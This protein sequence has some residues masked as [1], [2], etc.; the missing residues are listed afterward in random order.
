MGASSSFITFVNLNAPV[1]TLSIRRIPTQIEGVKEQQTYFS[2]CQQLRQSKSHF[3][4]EAK[5]KQC[6]LNRPK[7]AA[8]MLSSSVKNKTGSE[9]LML[10]RENPKN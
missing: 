7:D 5:P 3:A 8:T 6:R 4:N 2:N 9:Q 1:L 10:Q